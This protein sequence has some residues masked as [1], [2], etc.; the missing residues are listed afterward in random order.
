[1][2][3]FSFLMFNYLED[4]SARP[5]VDA[6]LAAQQIEQF[7]TG[8]EH[9]SRDEMHI[10]A[11]YADLTFDD[12]RD[13]NPAIHE[14]ML[15]RI[16]DMH[17]TED[18]ARVIGIAAE[19]FFIPAPT[20][21]PFLAVNALLSFDAKSESGE[22]RVA[23]IWRSLAQQE[24]DPIPQLDLLADILLDLHFLSTDRAR[25]RRAIQSL[26]TISRSEERRSTERGERL[27]AFST[28]L[29]ARL[30]HRAESLSGELGNELANL[31]HGSE[32]RQE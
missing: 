20:T 17:S 22:S 29:R 10:I 21:V 23:L 26:L 31:A 11:S 8:D 3:L 1:M 9:S 6:D 13:L 24:N 16:A 32:P 25:V 15:E 19:A 18:V 2:D 12:R 5:T 27:A 14:W 30:I 4:A 7:L 28:A